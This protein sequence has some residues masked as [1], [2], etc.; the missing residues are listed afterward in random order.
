[1]LMS[2]SRMVSVVLILWE[3]DTILRN[4]VWNIKAKS[5]LYCFREMNS[6]LGNNSGI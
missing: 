4:Y 6:Q 2:Y 3:V 1:M 5:M